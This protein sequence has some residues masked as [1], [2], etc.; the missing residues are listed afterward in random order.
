MNANPHARCSL[1]AVRVRAR[2][3]QR[4]GADALQA[5]RQERQGHL[6]GEAA[7]GLRRQGDPHGHRS[8][9]E[10]RDAAQVR[11][12]HSHPAEE[13]QARASRVEELKERLTQRKAALADAQNNPGEE[14]IG[15]LGTVKGGARPVPTEAYLKRLADLERAVKEAEADLESA[16]GGKR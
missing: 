15:R 8:Q 6:L 9:R 12:H 11:G 4:R 2:A 13:D 16:G 7:E 1:A 5:D 3:R 14:D 10:H